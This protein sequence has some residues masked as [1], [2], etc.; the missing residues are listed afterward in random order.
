MKGIEQREKREIIP[1]IP[2]AWV[3]AEIPCGGGRVGENPKF[4]SFPGIKQQEAIKPHGSCK[5]VPK[6]IKLRVE[7]KG[8]RRG[9]KRGKNGGEGKTEKFKK[10]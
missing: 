4:C 10:K 1:K 8:G 5:L 3:E 9:K 7:G 6:M 2:K